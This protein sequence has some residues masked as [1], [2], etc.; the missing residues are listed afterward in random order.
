[1]KRLSFFI[2]LMRNCQEVLMIYTFKIPFLVH[3]SHK[4]SKL[5][6]FFGLFCLYY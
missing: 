3:V 5:I 6:V 2:D 4:I 1:M